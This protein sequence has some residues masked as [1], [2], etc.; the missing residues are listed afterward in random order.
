M[1]FRSLCDEISL[2]TLSPTRPLRNQTDEPLL[3][4]V[5][6]YELHSSHDRMNPQGKL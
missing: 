3:K 4:E 2:R 1:S 6:H 5:L